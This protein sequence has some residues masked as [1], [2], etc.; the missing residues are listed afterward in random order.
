LLS[1]EQV[2]FRRKETAT[3]LAYFFGIVILSLSLKLAF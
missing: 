3:L 2:G 1:L